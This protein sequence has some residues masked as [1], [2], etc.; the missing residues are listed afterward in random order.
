MPRLQ[1]LDIGGNMQADKKM[2]DS[3]YEWL[4]TCPVIWYRIKVGNETVHYSFETPDMEES[5]NG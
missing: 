5:D 2:P 1:V 4:D 3:F